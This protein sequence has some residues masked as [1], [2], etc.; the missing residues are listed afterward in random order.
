MQCLVFISK[1]PLHLKCRLQE[2]VHR[3]KKSEWNRLTERITQTYGITNVPKTNCKTSKN[4]TKL[5]SACRFVF[6]I[7]GLWPYCISDKT[8]MFASFLS[9][10]LSAASGKNKFKQLLHLRWLQTYVEM[11]A[12]LNVAPLWNDHAFFT[13]S[14]L[15]DLF[16]E[17]Q[18]NQPL[19]G[20]A[21]VVLFLLFLYYS[22]PFCLPFQRAVQGIM[23]LWC[24][25]L[26]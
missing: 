26:N 3:K 22:L 13:I 8:K 4:Y 21:D 14:F 7:V 23:V 10:S 9:V 20:W 17:H 25:F 1:R 12:A 2:S 11:N 24:F 15:T 5:H 19:P 16:L 18:L 6:Y